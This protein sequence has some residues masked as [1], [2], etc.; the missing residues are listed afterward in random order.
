MYRKERI[1]DLFACAAALSGAERGEFLRREC[2]ADEALRREIE[3]LLAA[4]ENSPHLIGPFAFRVGADDET[5]GKILGGRYRIIEPLGKGGMGKVYLAE[6][7]EIPKLKFAVKI[8]DQGFEKEVE[9]LA[10]V[11]SDRVVMIFTT[12]KTDDG[13]PYMVMEYLTGQTLANLLDERGH[14]PREEAA[15]LIREICEAVTE[16]HETK[17]DLDGQGI[18]HRDLKP[19]NI[20]VA[21]RRNRWRIKLFDLGV[22]R[23]ENPLM[24]RATSTHVAKGTP[25]YMAPEQFHGKAMA[26]FGCKSQ[27]PSWIITPATDIY[28]LGVIAY[29]ML[30]GLNPFRGAANMAGVSAMQREGG[31]VKALSQKSEIPAAARSAILKAMAFCPE[32]RYQKAEE[33]GERLAEA[34]TASPPKAK[35]ATFA[36]LIL[37]VLLG[38][39]AL[40]WRGLGVPA[41]AGDNQEAANGNS[42]SNVDANSESNANRATDKADSKNDGAVSASSGPAPPR[43]REASYWL[44]TQQKVNDRPTGEPKVVTADDG[45]NDGWNFRLYFVGKERGYLYVINDGPVEDGGH[46]L[47]ILFPVPNDPLKKQNGNNGTSE[48]TPGRVVEAFDVDVDRVAGT[49]H[50]WIV[51]SAERIPELEKLTRYAVK[52]YG[53]R[54]SDPRDAEATRAFLSGLTQADLSYDER[55]HAVLRGEGN[56]LAKELLLKH[57]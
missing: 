12:G 50:L 15:Q 35:Y 38:L 46:L 3:G 36:A 7:I 16:L 29:E 40:M 39:G 55:G 21:R 10:R 24:G 11:K 33:F 22:A 5:L 28:S 13:R 32:A 41:G 49:E 4:G 6:D 30:V 27:S 56:V 45:L 51:W 37:L 23:L 8:F 34:L 18:I 48:I 53:G 47:Q 9:A 2:S 52:K 57:A 17:T 25:L 26:G 44:V 43:R 14:L 54:I 1:K 19:S 42:T 31:Y 20:M